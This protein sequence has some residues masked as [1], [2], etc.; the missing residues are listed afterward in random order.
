MYKREY[1]SDFSAKWICASDKYLEK[2]NRPKTP[3]FPN[4]KYIWGRRRQG[5][6]GGQG[7]CGCQWS[8]PAVLAV[9]RRMENNIQRR[10]VCRYM[11]DARQRH[12]HYR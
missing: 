2:F 8:G 1:K 3:E 4:A 7:I 11:A 12:N 5:P 10:R 6:Q 9:Y